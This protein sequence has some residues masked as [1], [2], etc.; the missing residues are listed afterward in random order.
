MWEVV[1]ESRFLLVAPGLLDVG[2]R[3]GRRVAGVVIAVPRR[4]T[5]WAGMDA[6]SELLSGLLSSSSGTLARAPRLVVATM[7]N[8]ECC[9]TNRWRNGSPLLKSFDRVS[10][11]A[12]NV[13]TDGAVFADR[14]C[15]DLVGRGISPLFTSSHVKS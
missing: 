4:R 8:D 9:G 13:H 12:G 5:G 7:A 1:L 2:S 10:C 14:G 15:S 3:E 6:L 11:Q